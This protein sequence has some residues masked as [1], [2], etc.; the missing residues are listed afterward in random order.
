MSTEIEAMLPEVTMRPQYPPAEV[1]ELISG[2]IAE[3][4]EIPHNDYLDF[5]RRHAGC[6][7][8]VGQDGY[9]RIWP[10]EEVISS[11]EQ[12]QTD[13]FA[14][15][16]LL[17]AGDGGGEAYAFDRHAA[18]WPI[19][20]APMVGLSRKAM[21]PVANSFGEFVRKLANDEI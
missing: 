7:G 21:K 2:F 17:F 1:E 15:G 19:V 18:G 13:R 11:T 4:G 10:L 5:M 14:P 16:L 9:I 12:L 8:P 6:D 3:V 20:S